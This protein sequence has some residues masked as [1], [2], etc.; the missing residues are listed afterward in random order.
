M[1]LNAGHLVVLHILLIITSLNGQE[2]D[3]F[4]NSTVLFNNNS[5]NY[6]LDEQQ[7]IPTAT[8]PLAPILN[9]FKQIN[10]IQSSAE[11]L[12]SFNLTQQ[13]TSTTTT[14]STTTSTTT[15]TIALAYINY[16]NLTDLSYDTKLRTLKLKY[17]FR[18]NFS[19]NLN[20]TTPPILHEITINCSSYDSNQFWFK[21]IKE[22]AAATGLSYLPALMLPYNIEPLP[23]SLINCTASMI[24]LNQ[25]KTFHSFRY[26]L[27][28]NH[29]NLTFFLN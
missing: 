8:R 26:L 18:A 16:F 2:I 28:S 23:G 15:T 29:L 12:K 20:A 25:F 19:S 11:L 27:T 14:T 1:S 7:Q 3:S 6:S 10:K 17:I 13:L 22:Q 5:M 4:T 21:S 9:L 24:D